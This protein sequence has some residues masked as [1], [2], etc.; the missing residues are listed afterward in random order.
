[1]NFIY[2]CEFFQVFWIFL[3][4]IACSSLVVDFYVSFL[5]F[6]RIS[7]LISIVYKD[8]IYCSVF[9]SL[10]KIFPRFFGSLLEIRDLLLEIVAFYPTF[11]VLFGS[12]KICFDF[13]RVFCNF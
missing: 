8:F 7:R 5:G 1:M 3:D 10:S 4:F 11:S 12:L 2:F 13:L 6:S 9:L